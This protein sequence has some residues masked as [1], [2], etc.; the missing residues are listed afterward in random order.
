MSLQRTTFWLVAMAVL[1]CGVAQ[2]RAQHAESPAP[3]DYYDYHNDQPFAP[4]DLSTYGG[5]PPGNQGFFAKY[6]RLLWS[7]S[8]PKKVPIG[9]TVLSDVLVDPNG[10]AVEPVLNSEDTGFF[11]AEANWGNRFA[12]GY[13]V[14][15]CGWI[16]TGFEGLSQ[17]QNNQVAPTNVLFEDP[18]NLLANFI[19][20]FSPFVV[21]NYFNFFGADFMHIKRCEFGCDQKYQVDCMTG[22]GY[23]EMKDLFRVQGAGTATSPIGSFFLNQD[24]KDHI[25]G[26]KVGAR[27]ARECGRFIWDVEGFF[28]A[29]INFRTIN[30]EGFLQNI[31]NFG[32]QSFKNEFTDV[33]FSPSGEFRMEYGYQLT[34]AIVFKIGYNAVWIGGVARAANTIDYE[35]P[36]PQIEKPHYGDNFFANGL[37]LGVEINR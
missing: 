27:C 5:H 36:R 1:F 35:V 29:G 30:Q 15:G 12:G 17:R 25:V 16:A 11:H 6:D 26:P 3:F 18:A 4:A 8:I 34:K 37:S 13:V 23:Y 22:V 9:T 10:N 14:D 20:E 19:P 7:M 32:D 33:R 24:V 31:T 2:S 28:T 21:D